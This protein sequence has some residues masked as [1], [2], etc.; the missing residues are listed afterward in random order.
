MKSSDSSGNIKLGLQKETN[1]YWYYK[2]LCHILQV[3]NNNLII[4]NY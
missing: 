4:I 1:R 2:V 3:I